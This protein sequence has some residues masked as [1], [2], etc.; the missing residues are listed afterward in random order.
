MH[1][2]RVGIKVVTRLGEEEITVTDLAPCPLCQHE[3][4][5]ENRFCGSCGARRTSGEQLATRQERCP[6]PATRAWPTMLGPATRALAVGVAVLA[7]EAS[8]SWLQRK[9]G[10]A[11]R[12]SV[13]TV[14]GADSTS[15][16]HL[17]GQSLE[18]VLVRTWEGSPD[19]GVF[20]RRVVRAFVTTGPT[21]GPR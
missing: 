3:N 18:E 17:V 14:R 19:S 20:A 13:P 9:V 1:S 16:G 7:A 2:I 21:D 15:R 5:L 4:P 12:S 10:A 8:M 11:D 6:V